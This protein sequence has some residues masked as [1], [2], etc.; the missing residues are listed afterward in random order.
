VSR[1]RISF[2]MMAAQ[3]LAADAIV[4]AFSHD[5]RGPVPHGG[6]VPAGKPHLNGI[7]TPRHGRSKAAR[8]VA[9]AQAKAAAKARKAG[10]Q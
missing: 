7:G 1:S 3:A 4:E 2:A 8:K 9:R 10:P 5:P 6:P